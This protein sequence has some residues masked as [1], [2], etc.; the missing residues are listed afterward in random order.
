[1]AWP[2]SRSAPSGACP[3]GRLKLSTTPTFC[4]Q[5]RVHI[6]KLRAYARVLLRNR[7]LADDLEQDCLER[8]LAKSHLYEQGTNLRAWLFTIMRNLYITQGRRATVVKR[9]A[10]NY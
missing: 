5:V 10:L 7:D 3:S 9:S 4:E 8:A 2:P 1:M 6:P